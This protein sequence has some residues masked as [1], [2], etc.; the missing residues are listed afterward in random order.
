MIHCAGCEQRIGNALG[1]LPGVATQRFAEVFDQLVV[2]SGMQF[3][4][5][6]PLAVA[7]GYQWVYLASY[8]TAPSMPLSTEAGGPHGFGGCP[9]FQSKVTFSDGQWRVSAPGEY[10]AYP[11]LFLALMLWNE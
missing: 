4:E 9:M 11:G 3:A 10:A 8:F 5:A 6:R 2:R 7:P 1:R